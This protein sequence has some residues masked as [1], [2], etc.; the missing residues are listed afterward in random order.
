MNKKLKTFRPDILPSFIAIIIV[1]LLTTGFMFYYSPGSLRIFL[2]LLKQQ[3]VL[4]FL[5][6]LPVILSM[7]IVYFVTGNSFLGATFPA[8]IWAAFAFCNRQKIKM[9]QDPVV[10]SDLA[11]FTEVKSLLK[12]FD[13]YYVKLGITIVVAFFI[14]CIIEII[15]IRKDK[16]LTWKKQ[17]IGAAVTIGITALLYCTT[18]TNTEL[19]D[20]F[21][22]DGNQYFKVNQYVS[23]G[24]TY[25]FLY[26]IENLKVAKP[27]NYNPTEF[28]SEEYTSRPDV[29]EDVAKPNIV[30]IM[31][32]AF[33][34]I[35]IADD[36]SFEGYDEPLE[37]YKEFI[38]RGDVL[39]GHI[40][41]PNF[42][43]G[44]SDTE[45]DV[46]TACSTRYIDSS[47]VSYNILNNNLEAIPSLLKNNGYDT[48]AIHPGYGWFYN[49]N[50]VYK[51]LGF[52]DF[53]SLETSF[54]AEK[55]NKGG[56]ISDEA[57]AESIIENF[58]NH[59][60]ESGN[61]LFEFCVTIQNHGPYG[62]KYTD[63]ARNFASNTSLTEDEEAIYSGY[64][65]GIDDADKQIEDLVNYFSNSDEPV[66]LVFFGDHLPGFSNGMTY[67]DQF[68]QDINMN[69]NIEERAKAYETPYFVWANDTAKTMTN[70]S[71]SIKSIDLPDN[72]IISSSFLGSTVME[73]LDMENI[74][75]FI[76]YANEIR[77]VMPVASGNIIM[78]PD[79][80]FTDMITADEQTMIEKY[81]R[82]IYY[83]I[84]DEYSFFK[85]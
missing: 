4:F 47:Q 28:E 59:T 85:E 62:E 12:N 7:L 25:S 50:N 77:R 11:V 78:Y 80:T 69:G 45:F 1:S 46:L 83:K 56:Y 75:P 24:F 13:P 64:F 55:Q 67:F 8:G 79:G 31:S 38:Q 72:H 9:R 65:E 49:R 23:K 40:V 60:A 82:W 5:N 32:E 51:L 71:K 10:P 17:L 21:M 68:R 14:I 3:P 41:V 36:I 70:Y 76:E 19:Y 16:K 43:G 73:L 74:S 29:L 37:F 57:T 53:L 20:S 48:L 34:D 42:G 30:M 52:D 61:P 22:V 63:L 35:S 39:S 33:S 26:D 2:S 44:T 58:E 66:V 27:D 54:D 15:F 84:F 81:K 6:Y 18:Y